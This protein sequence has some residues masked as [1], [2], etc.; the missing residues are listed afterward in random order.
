MC[1]PKPYINEYHWMV[2]EDGCCIRLRDVSLI[3]SISTTGDI[4][5]KC[6]VSG[7]EVYISHST[8]ALMKGYFNL[9]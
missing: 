5:A 9:E 4:A 6:I 3:T 7:S 8:Y 1:I 2:L